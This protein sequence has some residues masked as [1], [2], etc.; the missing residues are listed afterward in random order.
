MLAHCWDG[1][2]VVRL[3]F[4]H[5]AKVPIFRSIVCACGW[6]STLMYVLSA[7]KVPRNLFRIDLPSYLHHWFRAFSCRMYVRFGLIV[8]S[9][10][11]TMCITA[12]FRI[13][14]HDSFLVYLYRSCKKFYRMDGKRWLGEMRCASIRIGISTEYTEMFR[15]FSSVGVIKFSSARK[16]FGCFICS[17]LSW[18]KFQAQSLP[19]QKISSGNLLDGP[20]S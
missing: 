2:W 17:E 7:A 1:V 10:K 8:V 6:F 13:C 3:F 15:P 4:I 19:F 5:S 9:A 12:L 18:A 20:W 14:L 16:W 11:W